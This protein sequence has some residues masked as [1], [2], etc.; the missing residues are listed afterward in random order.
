MVGLGGG[1][2]DTTLQNLQGEAADVNLEEAEAEMK[3]MSDIIDMKLPTY[4]TWIK[5][6]CFIGPFLIEHI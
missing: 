5:R 2:G 6:L 4:S 1:G 3:V